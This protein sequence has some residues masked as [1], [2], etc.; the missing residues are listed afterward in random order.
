MRPLLAGLLAVLLMGCDNGRYQIASNQP[1]N[2]WR[3][4]TRTG[5]IA[6]CGPEAFANPPRFYCLSFPE[7]TQRKQP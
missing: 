2:V 4:D 7:T 3:L 1:G 6:S 5:E